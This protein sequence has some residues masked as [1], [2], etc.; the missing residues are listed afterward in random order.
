[1][2]IK[3]IILGIIIF[4]VFVFSQINIFRGILEIILIAISIYFGIVLG[5]NKIGKVGRGAE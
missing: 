4:F 5:K 1:M 2:K 3:L